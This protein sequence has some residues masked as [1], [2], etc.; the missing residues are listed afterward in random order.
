MRASELVDV[1]TDLIYQYDDLRVAFDG[2]EIAKVIHNEPDGPV[3]QDSDWFELRGK[4][5]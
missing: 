1:L 4:V 3:I 5:L 2:V